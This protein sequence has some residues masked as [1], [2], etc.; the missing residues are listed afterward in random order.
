MGVRRPKK[1]EN[2]NSDGDKTLTGVDL[3]P[4]TGDTQEALCH[5]VENKDEQKVIKL[6]KLGYKCH[7][8]SCNKVTCL[9]IACQ[10]GYLAITRHLLD[11]DFNIREQTKEY[12]TPLH[13]AVDR[14]HV[15]IAILLLQRGASTKCKDIRSDTPLFVACKNGDKQMVNTLLEFN[16]N[17]DAK[18]AI[19]Q[20][21]LHAARE[22]NIIKMLASRGL[23]IDNKGDHGNTPLHC[24]S[25]DYDEQLIKTLLDL[26]AD[27]TIKNKDG[28]T[29]RDLAEPQTWQHDKTA[30]ELLREAEM[31]FDPEHVS[32]LNNHKNKIGNKKDT[33][34]LTVVVDMGERKETDEKIG[35]QRALKKSCQKTRPE[36]KMKSNH[37]TASYKQCETNKERCLE[38]ISDKEMGRIA[39]ALE[40]KQAKKLRRM[41]P[42]T[43][44]ECTAENER[45]NCRN[46]YFQLLKIARYRNRKMTLENFKKKIA[47]TKPHLNQ[48]SHR[49]RISMEKEIENLQLT[50]IRIENLRLITVLTTLARKEYY[51]L[52]IELGVS[53]EAMDEIHALRMDLLAERCHQTLRKTKERFPKKTCA[54]VVRAMANIG[55][56]YHKA[57]ELLVQSE[58]YS[59]IRYR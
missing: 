28:K 40:R 19:G 35:T 30:L 54:D 49:E 26:G 25:R 22:S 34:T 57:M 50:K 52:G 21:P 31:T 32:D 9:H 53:S 45:G 4:V 59:P 10:R 43:L 56:D 33:N 18:D 23:D 51:L 48:M 24:A 15:A 17:V 14:G 55:L 13:E 6:L 41:V 58:H 1:K 36:H 47:L 42:W 7:P 2:A 46:E 37:Q 39:L 27:P 3:L 16:A 29:P 8:N 11:H 5:A 12:R 38:D 44:K 20:S